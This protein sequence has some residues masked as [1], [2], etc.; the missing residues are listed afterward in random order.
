L[1][2]E[3]GGGT[4][5]W[6]N[7]SSIIKFTQNRLSLAE[8]SPFCYKFHSFSPQTKA[9]KNLTFSF[10]TSLQNLKLKVSSFSAE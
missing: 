4:E 8:I 2:M 7:T 6:P 10:P 3:P 5:F 9:I 1:S